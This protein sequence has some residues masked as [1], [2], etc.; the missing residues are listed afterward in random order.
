[1]DGGAGRGGPPPPPFAV[2][3]VARTGTGFAAGAYARSPIAPCSRLLRRLLV[4]AWG[5]DGMEMGMSKGGAA[6]CR[7]TQVENAEKK[8][9]A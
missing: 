7:R 6:S 1:M 8:R 5:K 9:A 2:P 3:L 4:A